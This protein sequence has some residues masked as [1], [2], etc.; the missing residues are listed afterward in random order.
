MTVTYGYDYF[1]KVD[2]V[3]KDGQLALYVTTKFYHVFFFPILPESS[4]LVFAG[5]E[6][7]GA[8]L[9]QSGSNYSF[10]GIEIEQSKKSILVAWIR[11]VAVLAGLVTMCTGMMTFA[12]PE[13]VKDR[14]WVIFK[15]VALLVTVAL[16]YLIAKATP[17]RSDEL[18]QLAGLKKPA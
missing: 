3:Y 11:A 17:D 1:G 8:M 4:H 5:S 7:S 15:V 12:D 6:N 2:N 9:S 18:L 16:T 13:L 14:P 10:R